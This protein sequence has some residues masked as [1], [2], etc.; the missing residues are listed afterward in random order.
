MVSPN[1]SPRLLGVF[2]LFHSSTLFTSGETETR[3][4]MLHQW[5]AGQGLKPAQGG[6]SGVSLIS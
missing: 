5:C 4:E 1:T 3:R 6:G 2:T